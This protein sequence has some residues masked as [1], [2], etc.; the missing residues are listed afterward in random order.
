MFLDPE[1][2]RQKLQV[3]S[4]PF[5]AAQMPAERAGDQRWRKARKPLHERTLSQMNQRSPGKSATG[6]A[7]KLTPAPTVR[8]VRHSPT[9]SSPEQSPTESDVGKLESAHVRVARTVSLKRYPSDRA[10]RLSSS[11]EPALVQEA[12]AAEQGFRPSSPDESV[13]GLRSSTYDEPRKLDLPPSIT[14]LPNNATHVVPKTAW[15]RRNASS[16]NYS[17]SSTLRDIDSSLV[18]HSIRTDRL[19]GGTTLRGTPTPYEQEHPKHIDLE[20]SRQ[21]PAYA[22]QTLQEASPEKPT[23]RA[24]PPSNESSSTH[25]RLSSIPSETSLPR[26]RTAQSPP[27]QEP[28]SEVFDSSPR[29][30]SADSIAPLPQSVRDYSHRTPRHQQS[31]ESLSPNQ[32]IFPEASSPIFVVYGSDPSRPRSRSQPL[33]YTPSLESIQSRLQYPSIIRPD[34][35]RSL[36]RTGSS[37]SYHQP[38]SS[39]DTLAPLQVTRKRPRNKPGPV[40]ATAKTSDEMDEDYDTLPYPRQQF[41]SH[42]STIAS[43]S[44]QQSRSNSRQLSHFSLG[45]GV[46]T[47]DDASSIPLSGRRGR[48]GSAPVDSTSSS[49]IMRLGRSSEEQEPGDMTLGIFR[50]ESA[51]PEPLFDPRAGVGGR[52]YDGPLPPIPPIPKGRDEDENFDTVSELQQPSLRPKRSGY[53]LR[54]RSNSTPSRSGSHSRQVSQISY[55]DSDRGSHGSSIFPLWAKNFYGGGATLL[56]SSKISLGGD[57]RTP[58]PQQRQQHGRNASNWTERSVTSRLGTGYSEIESAS[59]SSSRFLPS[60]FRPRTRP[61]GEGAGRMSNLRRSKRSRPSGDTESRPDSLAIFSEPFPPLPGAEGEVLPSGQPKF[62]KLK[63]NSEEEE[64]HAHRPLQRKYSK[65]KHWN[66]M[67]FPRPMTKDRL[68][69]FALEHP[70]LTPSRRQGRLSTWRPPSFVESLD[71]LVRSRCNRQILLFAL[72]FICPLLWMLGAVLPLPSRPAQQ[73]HEKSIGGSEEDVQMAM[74]KH[75]AGD[76]ERRWREEKQWMKARWWRTLN[77]V[78]SIIGVLVIGAVIALA[79]VATRPNSRLS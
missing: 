17:N 4:S 56:S 9:S 10:A 77:R 72:G 26:P 60:I 35:G 33:R 19:S 55:I 58:H 71:T 2:N 63:D 40:S 1:P 37:A 36:A 57:Y 31:Q 69:D 78:M 42:L 47:G 20:E 32:S 34:T 16:G 45:S 73:D 8:L 54:N 22:L 21:G 5:F 28:P 59:P 61:K 64:A 65:Q 76:A 43:E 15:H 23:V 53:S 7:V 38:S 30:Y 13:S 68:S 12:S 79:V 70:H 25:D 52:K 18:T 49:R 67:Q 46:L 11:A 3:S 50:E 62:G 44:D 41:S 66:E 74:M 6:G 48:R 14:L 75:E 39:V 29:R 24:I 27:D 51:K